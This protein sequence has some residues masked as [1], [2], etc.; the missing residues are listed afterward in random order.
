MMHS[1]PGDDALAKLG[2]MLP[3]VL[4]VHLVQRGPQ[5]LETLLN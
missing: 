3:Q 1:S 2:A 4:A 5:L